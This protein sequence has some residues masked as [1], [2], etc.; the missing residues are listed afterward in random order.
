[1]DKFLFLFRGGNHH[2]PGNPPEAMKAHL[3]K[4]MN[5]IGDLTKKGIY[6]GGDALQRT[7]K[8]VAG[9]KKSV[10]DGP[11]IEAKEMIGGYVIVHAKDIHEA[12]EISKGCP[13]LETEGIVEVRPIQKMEM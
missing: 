8:Q 1:M 10:T 11:F 4:M 7:G 2:H 12:V 3:Q 13:N 6:V 9:S 5:W